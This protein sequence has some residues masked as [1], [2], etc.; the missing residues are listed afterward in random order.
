MNNIHNYDDIINIPRPISKNHKP[1]TRSQ[2]AAQF[3]PFAALKGYEEAI[4]ETQRIVVE[5]KILSEDEKSIISA[6][7]TYLHQSKSKEEIHI[8]YF[9]KDEKKKGGTYQEKIGII[10]K[11]DDVELKIY[12]TDKT[13]I[14]VN[15]IIN[16]KLPSCDF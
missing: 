11:I 8:T 12:F 1:M 9:V 16:I 3:S 13:V 6:K 2:R 7:L 5:K 15:D 10:R 14:A 4:E